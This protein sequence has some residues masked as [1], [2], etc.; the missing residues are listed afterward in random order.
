MRWTLLALVGALAS[1]ASAVP[2]S[3]HHV[4]HERRERAPR[5][6]VKKDRL[7]ANQPLPVRVALT[8]TNLHLGDKL[9]MEV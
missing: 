2:A 4:V 9:L 5:D 6:W 7:D 3:T 8:Q 1:F